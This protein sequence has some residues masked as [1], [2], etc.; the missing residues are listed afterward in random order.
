MTEDQAND[1]RQTADSE[2]TSQAQ[3]VRRAL[4]VCVGHPVQAH[5]SAVR[6]RALDLAGAFASGLSDVS[7]NHDCY[8][9]EAILED[10]AP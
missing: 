5:E 4:E 3:I 9:A 8:L 1:W 6:A 7:E 2:G 10:N